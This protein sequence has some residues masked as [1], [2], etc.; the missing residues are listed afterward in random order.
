MAILSRYAKRPAEVVMASA[1]EDREQSKNETG[2]SLIFIGLTLWV[3][4]SL[5]VF[6]LPA[7][8]RLGSQRIFGTVILA[9]AA[10]GLAL[11]VTGYLMRGKPE[12]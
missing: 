1:L 10:A 7:S 9:M 3:A 11:M 12:E 6:F 8:V 4:D 2:T 5:V